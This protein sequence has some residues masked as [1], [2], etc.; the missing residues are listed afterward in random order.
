MHVLP[1][2]HICF[3]QGGMGTPRR[4]AGVRLRRVLFQPPINHP[5][6]QTW[7]PRKLGKVVFRKESPRTQFIIL[8]TY[9]SAGIVG[10]KPDHKIA[11]I[12]P[13]LIS[14]IGDIRNLQPCLLHHFPSHTFFQCLPRLQEAGNQTIKRPLEIAGMNQQN[15]IVFTYQHQYSRR[16]SRI[17]F[18][19]AG[20]TPLRYSRVEDC[21]RAANRAEATVLIPINQL[22]CLSCHGIQIFIQEVV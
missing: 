5:P 15:R 21:R 10:S 22:V 1:S 20:R 19:S 16:H 14:E 6:S 8:K 2:K 18:V 3:F 12:G 4:D 11:R 17:Y 9:R 13:W 7:F